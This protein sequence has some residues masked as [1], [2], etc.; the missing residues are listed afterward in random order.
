MEDTFD[1]LINGSR[2]GVIGGSIAGCATAI[3]LSRLGCHVTIL[4]R[5][6]TGLA[7]RG[8][9][10][11]VPPPLR[12]ELVEHGYLPPDYRCWKGVGRRWCVADE[13]DEGSLQWRQPG[14]VVTN[15]WGTLW[16]GLRAN[17]PVEVD[18]VDGAMVAD[19]AEGDDGVTLRCADGKR[20]GLRCG[21]RCR[22]V[23]VGGAPASASREPTAVSPATSCGAG[24]S[25]P[26]SSATTPP[27]TRS[28]SWASG[29]RSDSMAAHGGHVSDPGLRQHPEG[30]LA[31]ELGH[32]RADAR[33][34]RTGR[35]LVH[36]AGRRLRMA[37]TRRTGPCWLRSCHQSSHPCST[38]HKIRYRY[39]RCMTSWSIATPGGVWP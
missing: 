5:S 8:S 13:T 20:T 22:W 7:D 24:T 28:S 35:T 27:G 2:V 6:S 21:D 17:V 9:G 3:A 34:T 33:R 15:N 14:A 25:R 12:D 37:C 16:R 4:E 10:I 11:A 26:S 23:Q 39:S 32:L 1:T 38:V 29:S 19:V 31:R 30:R 36:S 18:Y